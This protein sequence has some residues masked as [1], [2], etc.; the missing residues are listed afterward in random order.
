MPPTS[1]KNDIINNKLQHYYKAEQL[2][3]LTEQITDKLMQKL[4]IVKA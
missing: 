1:L 2:Q 3:F 4:F